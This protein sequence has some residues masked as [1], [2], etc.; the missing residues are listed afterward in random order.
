MTKMRMSCQ[1]LR[2]IEHL[3]GKATTAL[4]AE[5]LPEIE[6]TTISSVIGN[7]MKQDRVIK[8]GEVEKTHRG[9]KRF[10]YRVN[11]DW[12]P[13]LARKP[14]KKGDYI[15]T[16]PDQRK[17]LQ[18]SPSNMIVVRYRE[19]K[20]KMLLRLI[21]AGVLNGNENDLM[22]GLLADLGYKK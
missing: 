9:R 12:E 2:Q 8:C 21:D 14:R 6:M 15:P 20:Q 11:D 16:P 17:M 10:Y 13:G 7:M 1:I 3:K 22:L 18:G 4:L 5:L 19:A